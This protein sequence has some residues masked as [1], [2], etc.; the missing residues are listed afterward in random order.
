MRVVLV[1]TDFT[2]V[3]GRA[4]DRASELARSLNARLHMLHVVEP[5]DDP[6]ESDEDTRG[7]H[8][9][10]QVRAS[11]MLQQR[12][13][14]LSGLAVSYSVVLGHRPQSI[15]R[16]AD[17]EEADLLVLGTHP[18]DEGDRPRGSTSQRVSWFSRRPVL[19]VP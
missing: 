7:F 19:L 4:E 6:E 2:E 10:L 9:D 5:I 3:S 14:R 16:V 1:A 12:V 13:G 18:M 17:Q 8:H 15:L 11:E